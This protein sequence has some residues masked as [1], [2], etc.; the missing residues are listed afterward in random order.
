MKNVQKLL[1]AWHVCGKEKVGP[2]SSP[3]TMLQSFLFTFILLMKNIIS[4]IKQI[5]N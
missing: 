4:S 2:N 1:V 3:F 5:M